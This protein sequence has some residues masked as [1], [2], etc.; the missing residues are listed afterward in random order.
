VGRLII[1]IGIT[2][3]LYACIHFAC[4][5]VGPLHHAFILNYVD[6]VIEACLMIWIS[7]KFIVALTFANNPFSIIF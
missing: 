3:K 1:Y 5:E 6:C 4:V 2:K 7:R